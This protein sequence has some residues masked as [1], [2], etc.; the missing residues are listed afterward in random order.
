MPVRLQITS[1]CVPLTGLPLG[2][3][4]GLLWVGKPVL[5]GALPARAHPRTPGAQPLL[6]RTSRSARLS[7]G[8]IAC[9]QVYARLNLVI[10]LEESYLMLTKSLRVHCREL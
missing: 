7:V 10:I 5:C 6:F 3:W 2:L 8:R 4:L 9:Y 1:L